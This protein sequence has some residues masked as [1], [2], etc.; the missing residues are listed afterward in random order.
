MASPLEVSVPVTFIVGI[1]L[2]CPTQRTLRASCKHVMQINVLKIEPGDRGRAGVVDCYVWTRWGLRFSRWRNNRESG[3]TPAGPGFFAASL[4]PGH[5][6]TLSPLPE[7]FTAHAQL[8]GEFRLAH[9]VLVLQHET[10]EILF[11]R[12]IL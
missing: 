3:R 2:L 6:E 4:A 7:A 8:A 9:V 1:L 11:E 12:E 5:A 10:L